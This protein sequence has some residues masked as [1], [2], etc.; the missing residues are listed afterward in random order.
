MFVKWLEE[1]DKTQFWID[2]TKYPA[3]FF[4]EE[5][6]KNIHHAGANWGVTCLS[7]KEN[8][9]KV[10]C[11]MRTDAD[12]DYDALSEEQILDVALALESSYCDS[13][14]SY[15]G[16]RMPMIDLDIQVQQKWIE[17]LQNKNYFVSLCLQQF[18][19]KLN[20]KGATAKSSA[21]MLLTRSGMISHTPILAF[22]KP[23]IL[24]FSRD[25]LTYPAFLAVCGTDCWKE[26]ANLD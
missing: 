23:F 10:Y 25:D 13:P 12:A 24:W 19:L 9:T 2:E 11:A 15:K 14:A 3:V 6:G 18:I 20:E 21:V 7:T 22:N 8:N 1:G 16:V 5:I 17:K 4:K 26:P